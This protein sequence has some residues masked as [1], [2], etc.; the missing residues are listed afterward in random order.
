MEELRFPISKSQKG[1]TVSLVGFTKNRVFNCNSCRF[2]DDKKEICPYIQETA[3][4]PAPKKKLCGTEIQL[5]IVNASDKTMYFSA[6][7][8]KMIDSEGYD[9]TGAQVCDFLLSRR[10]KSGS[11]VLPKTQSIQKVVFPELEE[12]IEPYMFLFSNSDIEFRFVVGTLSNN[13]NDLFDKTNAESIA[14][15]EKQQLVLSPKKN[16]DTD[17]YTKTESYK[18]L[19]ETINKKHPNLKKE[20]LEPIITN[21]SANYFRF[22]NNEENVWEN[23]KYLFKH[24]PYILSIA[25]LIINQYDN[26]IKNIITI[27]PVSLNACELI[28][29]KHSIRYSV[30]HIK[31]FD[32]DVIA[33]VFISEF[34]F[35]LFS[36]PIPSTEGRDIWLEIESERIPCG[37]CSLTIKKDDLQHIERVT[38]GLFR[39][40][41]LKDVQS[42]ARAGYRDDLGEA[43]RSSWEAN[44]ARIFRKKRLSY[45][46]E[47]KVYEMKKY[48]YMPDFF[49]DDG[50]IIE[51]KGVWDDDSRGKILEFHREHPETRLL[52]IDS[53]LFYDLER[54]FKGLPNWE[55]TKVSL[56]D[57]DIPVVGLSFVKDKSVFKDLCEGTELLLEREMDNPYDS[58]A[59]AVTLYDGRSL[60]HM[61]AEWAAIYAPKIDAGIRYH[62]AVKSIQSKVIVVTVHRKN[63]E[64]EVLYSI[65]FD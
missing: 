10:E 19:L 40:L 22:I 35:S 3:I 21:L 12:N 20:Y 9:F 54:R 38:L 18:A 51:V 64:E 37:Y 42:S 45:R 46:Y 56:K 57:Q 7:Y 6:Y 4:K 25:E 11:E 36:S 32:K 30:E 53:D 1:I 47:A 26:A 17:D 63:P 27:P 49:L 23:E 31:L 62:V 28:L 16:N 59:I 29:Q 61:G 8:W 43:F 33:I 41:N 15:A 34:S 2:V 65:F 55:T 58:N 39:E 50:T 48:S 52:L 5:H 24:N 13:V 44:I 60:G 14:D